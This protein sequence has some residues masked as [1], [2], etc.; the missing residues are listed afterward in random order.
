MLTPRS[1][2]FI[3][4]LDRSSEES[5]KSVHSPVEEKGPLALASEHLFTCNVSPRITK[6]NSTADDDDD[7]QI[8]LGLQFNNRWFIRDSQSFADESNR[9]LNTAAT[10][11]KRKMRWDLAWKAARHQ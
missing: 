4:L 2:F 11:A 5:S 6:R 10:P 7:H 3:A 9:G 1:E 8:I